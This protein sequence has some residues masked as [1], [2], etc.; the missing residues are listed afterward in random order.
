MI[1]LYHKLTGIHHATHVDLLILERIWLWIYCSMLNAS[2][3]DQVVNDNVNV[4]AIFIFYL[5]WYSARPHSIRVPPH[6]LD[7]IPQR[8]E[9]FGG[10]GCGPA[11]SPIQRVSYRH[12]APRL[13]QRRRKKL[14]SQGTQDL[15]LIILM[16]IKTHVW[17][18]FNHNGIVLVW[19]FE[20][21]G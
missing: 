8:S 16:S 15:N 13:I 1:V 18:L 11:N 2:D 12:E 3:S 19:N 7:P 9:G 4:V 20:N 21:W 17:L 6:L 5:Y 10:G 14:D